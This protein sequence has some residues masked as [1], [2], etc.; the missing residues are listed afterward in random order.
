MCGS[1]AMIE[2]ELFISGPSRILLRKNFVL[3][4][5]Y[6]SRIFLLLSSW[7][8]DFRGFSGVNSVVTVF[9]PNTT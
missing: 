4:L 8:Y 3:V 9:D 5:F 6:E 1:Y 7:T 2:L